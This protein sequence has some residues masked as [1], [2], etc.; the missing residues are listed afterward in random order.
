[1]KQMKFI[2]PSA[3]IWKT[4]TLNE[5]ASWLD[6]SSGEAIPSGIDPGYIRQL[7]PSNT[8]PSALKEPLC[9]IIIPFLYLLFLPLSLPLLL[10]LLIQ[11]LPP[12]SQVNASPSMAFTTPSDRVMKASLIN[13]VIN[14][15]LPPSG[16]PEWVTWYVIERDDRCLVMASLVPQTLTCTRPKRESG[17]FRRISWLCWVS[18]FEKRVSQSERLYETNHVTSRLGRNTDRFRDH[19]I[20]PIIVE[21]AKFPFARAR[22]A[23]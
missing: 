20:G 12:F 5:A 23:V 9:I 16:Y 2:G 18:M 22:A 7:G 19:G 11:L 8:L 21:A 15:V 4:L 6:G 17:L 10:F 1:M 13:D 14:I 3:T